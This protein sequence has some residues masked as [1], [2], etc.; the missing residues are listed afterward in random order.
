MVQRKNLHIADVTG[1]KG[2]NGLNP[3][4]GTDFVTSGPTLD[5]E[6]EIRRLVTLN[7]NILAGAV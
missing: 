4:G 5:Y 7:P 3:T 6:V 2:C 1:N